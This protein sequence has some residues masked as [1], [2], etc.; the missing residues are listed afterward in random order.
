M[1]KSPYLRPAALALAVGLLL[2]AASSCRADLLLIPPEP[3]SP[4]IA[5]FN[6]HLSYNATSR[7][8]HSDSNP[9]S[10]TDPAFGTSLFSGA[11]QVTIDL[12][13]DHNGNFISSGTGFRLTGSLDLDSDGTPDVSGTL[14]FGTITAFGADAP[15]PP[16]REFD[17]LFT[18]EGGQLTQNIPLSGGG[19]RFG[20]FSVGE[21]GGFLL[22]AE[23][24]TSG[25]L[26]DFSHDF[27]SSNVKDNEFGTAVPEPSSF[28]LV[29]V[30]GCLLA[31]LGCFRKRVLRPG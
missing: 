24:V 6:G 7:I 20:G 17:G 2:V 10:F 22:F 29:L 13:V 5:S 9:L 28:V 15:G 18:I 26:G 3:T 14:L 25:T 19:T 4:V 21:T 12:T 30:G 23:N 1:K 27:A 16:S 31:G 11:G 8:F